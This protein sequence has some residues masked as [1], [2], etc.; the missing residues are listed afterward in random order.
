MPGRRAVLS[1]G[2][3]IA[4]Q[5]G[6]YLSKVAAGAEEYYLGSG[7]AA[8]DWIGDG[9][10]LLGLA[11]VVDGDVLAAVLDAR[12]PGE[13]GESLIT[14]RRPD[15][16]RGFDLTF[17]APKGVS[18]LFAL[19]E[20]E[21]ARAMRAAHDAAVRAALAYL[22]REGGEVR[23]GKDGA[24]RLGG[25]G[26]VGAAFRHRTSRAGD[27]QLHTHVLVANMTRGSDGRWSALDSKQL[28]AQAKTAGCLYQAV[29]RYELRE[30]GLEWTVRD[31]GLSELA[32]V[33]VKVLRAFSRRRVEIEARLQLTGATSKAG[34]QIATLDTRQPKEGAVDA[35]SLFAEWHARADELGFTA[36]ARAQLLGAH[37]VADPTSAEL[38]RVGA[39]L[40]GPTGLTERASMFTRKEVL[41]AYARA[42]PDG[43]AVDELEALSDGLLAT[44]E[45]VPVDPVAV[46]TAPHGGGAERS[47]RRYSTVELL[48]IEADLLAR[49]VAGR[50]AALGQVDAATVTATLAAHPQ[51]LDE[52]TAMVE[53]LLSSGDAVEVVVGKAG[54][55]KTTTLAAA[56]EAWQAAGVPVFGAAVA[57]R[58][59]LGL[60]AETGIPSRTVAG[61]LNRIAD[62]RGLPVPDGGVLVV[63][64]AGML[65]TRDLHT[66]LSAC[67][68]GRVKLVLIGD[69][70]QLPELAAGGAFHALTRE[71]DPIWL[72]INRRQTAP[73]ERVALDELRHGKVDKALEAY[74]AA[75]RVRA[76]P[77][78][79]ES[80][81]RLVDDWWHAATATEQT[82]PH[83][84]DVVGEGLGESAASVARPDPGVVMIAVRRIDVDELNLR[85]REHM[86]A[87]GHLAGEDLIV[88]ISP[89]VERPFAVGDVIAARRNC[90][91]KHLINGAR[92]VIT[93]LDSAAGTLTVRIHDKDID[94]P[95]DYLEAG[96]LDHGYALT[97]HQAQGMT[98]SRSFVRVGDEMYREAGYV[99]MSRARDGSTAYVA[100]A[101]EPQH[102]IETC[103]GREE[104]REA[105]DAIRSA[106]SRSCAQELAQSTMTDSFDL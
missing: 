49:A 83:A 78:A 42:H 39:E 41:Q 98:A 61:V 30:L 36:D 50:A 3:L 12:R 33:D 34:A 7:E 47:A 14:W 88:P 52:Q 46:P 16:V 40:L 38:L 53:R 73:W 59:A 94:I 77:T 17:S 89:Y 84:A 28:Y 5:E 80:R 23:R 74:V 71:L 63:D 51:L 90:W 2:K 6:Y 43:A 45:S 72:N 1:I 4:G 69:Y 20:P 29:L 32:G 13:G 21:V 64:E 96:H 44:S 18:L 22:E 70:R 91:P 99:A 8:G 97:V 66:L 82:L 62:G 37:T 86:R 10:P 79:P 11:G 57:A 35:V 75:E 81:A 92:G 87:A 9:A 103:H 15:R 67:Q 100:G 56:Y 60:Q 54:T 48:G 31:N 102:D 24:T 19:G 95:R 26:F 101:K 68:D 104:R 93:A 55:G 105:A 76:A 58:A 25:S 85:A 106:W 27:P 65:G